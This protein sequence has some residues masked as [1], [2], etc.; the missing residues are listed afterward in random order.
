[1]QHGRSQSCHIAVVVD[2]VAV[3]VTAAMVVAVAT[4]ISI[5]ARGGGRRVVVLV[6]VSVGSRSG[7]A[8]FWIWS[9]I[10]IVSQISL[11]S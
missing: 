8:M 11:Y 7:C 2:A 3:A 1:M 9:N 4:V 5:V 6:V 10:N